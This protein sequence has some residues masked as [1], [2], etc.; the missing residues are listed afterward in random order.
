MKKT[1]ENI[2][3]F[4]R[5]EWE[6]FG[7]PLFGRDMNGVLKVVRRWLGGS[8]GG[9]V[10][11]VATVNP[12][13]VMM[14]E[15]DPVFR[16]I[17]LG[18]DLRVVDGIGLAWAK[19]LERRFMIYDSRF[20][21]KTLIRVWLGFGVGVG[22][23]RGRYKDSLVTGVELMDKMCGLGDRVGFLG[24]W[25]NRAERTKRF[26]EKKYKNFEGVAMG[27][28]Y[29][30]QTTT[31]MET[32]KKNKVKILLVAYGM[33]KQERWM[34]ANLKALDRAGVKI[35]MGVG[36]SFDYYSGDLAR[37]PEW[38]R[39]MGLEW[40]YSLIREPKRWRR[41]LVLPKFVWKVLTR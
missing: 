4:G 15:K 33:E 38:L 21:N 39:R 20:M 24:G 14:A 27:S 23:L 10:K 22:V 1:K 9:G 7:L 12:E 40:L 37:A 35:A 13:F 36:R 34:V 30:G 3:S 19:E 18:A 11:M 31:I 29:D 41:Q 26:F 6:M 8:I 28:E 25:G 5:S 2:V 16:K 32:I 17:L